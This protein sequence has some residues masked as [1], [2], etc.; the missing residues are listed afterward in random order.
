LR[1]GVVVVFPAMVG[2]SLLVGSPEAL[3]ACLSDRFAAAG[4][5]DVGGDVAD[6]RV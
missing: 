1:S 6:A 4:V 2:D 5:F 3:E